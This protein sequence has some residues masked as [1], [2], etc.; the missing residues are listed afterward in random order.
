MTG[1][2]ECVE[3]SEEEL[4]DESLTRFLPLDALI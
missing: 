3:E 1:A 4:G 2:S